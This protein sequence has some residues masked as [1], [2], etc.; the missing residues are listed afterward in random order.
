MEGRGAG[1]G[2][3][4]SGSRLWWSSSSAKSMCSASRKE[5][6]SEHIADISRDSPKSLGALCKGG[7]KSV[8]YH[9]YYNPSSTQ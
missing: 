3:V 2:A 7:E 5:V 9:C 8:E 6:V 1:G 4:R